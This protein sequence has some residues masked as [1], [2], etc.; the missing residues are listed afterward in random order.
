MTWQELDWLRSL[1]S[2]P[3]VLKGLRTAEDARV[4]VECGVDGILVSNHGGRQ[5]DGTMSAI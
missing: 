4:A 5:M 3:L 1:T 2:L